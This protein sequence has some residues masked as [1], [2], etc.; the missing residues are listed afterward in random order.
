[1]FH[2]WVMLVS[3]T[4]YLDQA[5]TLIAG[6]LVAATSAASFDDLYRQAAW[7]RARCIVVTGSCTHCF[8]IPIEVSGVKKVRNTE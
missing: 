2:E 7:L 4:I 5:H 8:T 6:S 1:M 3:D